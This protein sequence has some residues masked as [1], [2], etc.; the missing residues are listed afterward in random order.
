MIKRI[1][2]GDTRVTFTIARITKVIGVNSRLD[3]GRHILMWDF[4]DMPLDRVAEALRKVQARYFLSEIY[5]LKSSEPN[6][7]IAY[8]FTAKEWQEAV[9]ILAQTK[10]V[11]E[12]FFK[13]GVYRGRFT[14]R[15]SEKNGERP[16]LVTKLEGYDLANCSVKELNSWVRYETLKGR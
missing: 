15:V 14:L 13:Y 4:D 10:G 2:I 6:N 11:D 12:N 8:C 1:T 3:D 7:Y 9:E 5:I 16:H